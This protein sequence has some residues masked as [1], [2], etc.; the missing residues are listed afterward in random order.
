[1]GVERIF[2]RQ[3]EK[4]ILEQAFRSPEPEFIAIYGRRRV[5][6]THLVREFFDDTIRFE[7]IGK[8]DA[9]LGEQLENFSHALGMAIGMGIQ[10]QKP[11][12]WAE[13]FRQ[14]EQFLESPAHKDRTGKRVVFLDELPW[15]STPRSRFL[16]GLE[17]FWNSWGSRQNDF[18]LVICGSA[19]SWMI[20]NIVQAKG[21]LHNRLTRQIRLLPFTLRETEEFLKSRGV[22]L[23]RLQIVELYMAMGGIPHYLK[24]AEPG[25]SAIQ[26]IDKVCFSSHGLLRDEFD[27]L[28]AS[29]FE[30]SGQHQK[31][32]KMLAKKRKGLTR[33]EILQ[34][35]GIRS[36]GS[37]SRRIEELEESGFIQSYIPF[38]KKA[39]D[40]LCR[41]SDEYSLF[42][43]DWISN[44][45]KR[46]PG[47]GYWLSQQNSPRRRAWAG[48]AFESLCIKHA[49][50]LKA[51]LGIA[52]VE[53]T[54]APWRYQSSQKSDIPGAQI[55]LLIDRRDDTINLCEMKYSETEFTIDK[56]YAQDLRQKLN[57][58]LRVTGTRKNVFLTM[59]TTFGVTNNAYAKELVV[60]TLTLD[61]LFQTDY[62]Q[63]KTGY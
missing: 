18:I 6:K 28:Y 32:V 9:T 10:P 56:R 19:A 50:S 1:M 42:Y 33:S 16:S 53:T 62:I 5:G 17:H 45:G 11:P 63:P 4:A 37:A 15:L 48:Y 12:S 20:Q 43:L 23:T 39:N 44:L 24:Q 7:I 47:D 3:E 8:H 52:K 35:I 30:E 26:L 60:N 57:V 21:G 38:G 36:G 40:A 2:G 51:A 22:D 25:L 13:A 27:K 49:P 54:E 46:S 31:I 55:D 34:L 29:L 14:L 61:A 58:F 59:L 41:L